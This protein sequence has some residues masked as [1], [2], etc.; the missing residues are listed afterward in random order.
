MSAP[1]PETIVVV[2]T[3]LAGLRAIEALRGE[4]HDG[5]IVAI[6]AEP[7]LPYDRP[8]LSKQFLKGDWEE[9]RLALR[10]GGVEDLDVAWRLGVGAGALDT[11]ERAVVLEDG[12]RV[13]YDRLLIATGAVA[14]SLPFGEELEGIHLLRTLDDSRA[15]RDDL[16]SASRVLIV[17]AGFIGMEVAAT[18]RQRGLEVT[19]VEPMA[20]P[21]LR[22]LGPELGAWVGARHAEEGIAVRCG[23]GV[24]GFEGGHRVERVKLTDGT[25]L[26]T[27]VVVVGVGA[28]PATDWLESSG[29]DLED[30]IVCDS[31]GATRAPDVFAAGDVARWD[32]VRLEHWTSAVEQAGHVAAR[33]L[34]GDSVGPLTHLPYVWTDQFELRLQIAGRIQPGDEM[35]VC[36]G[37]LDPDG[38]RRFVALYGRD[39]LLR[40]AVANK[41]PRQLIAVRKLLAT[42]ASFEGAVAANA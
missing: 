22:G 24:E 37:S 29:L 19:V 27:D 3:S 18:C 14:R 35:H 34:R 41:R 12:E 40:G 13:P 36:H 42:G 17:G 23:V 8:P 20:Q 32:G 7:H 30:G 11:K 5:R 15:L 28:R 39:G 38:E 21:L 25:S 16:A 31:S 33:M 4:E 26:E 1:K 9:D 10:R 2:G 6:G